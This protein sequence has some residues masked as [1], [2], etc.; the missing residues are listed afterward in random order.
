MPTVKKGTQAYF[1]HKAKCFVQRGNGIADTLHSGYRAITGAEQQYPGELHAKGHS[2]LGPR[3]SLL[4]RE[5]D[6]PPFNVPISQ[7]DALAKTHDIAYAKAIRN[8]D[9]DRNKKAF[10]SDIHTADT[11]FIAA[12][13]SH[14]TLGKVSAGLMSTKMLAE[15]AGVL[16]TKTFSGRGMQQP[17][18]G[19]SHTQSVKGQHIPKYVITALKEG[20]VLKTK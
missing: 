17:A 9:R 11:K 14:G 15:K 20:R 2:Y 12:A 7:L 13:P 16:D 19:T 18:L 10:V 6:G 3:S 8:Y 5:L 1:D 4:Q